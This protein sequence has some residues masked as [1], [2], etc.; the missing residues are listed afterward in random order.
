[1]KGGLRGSM[2]G[3]SGSAKVIATAGL[4]VLALATV[5]L[6][7]ATHRGLPLFFAWAPL[8]GVG[9]VLTRPETGGQPPAPEEPLSDDD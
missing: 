3:V 4:L 5:V 9:W 7:A 6:S 2:A 1:M 8:V